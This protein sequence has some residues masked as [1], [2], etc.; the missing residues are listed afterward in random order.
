MGLPA[1]LCGQADVAAP[2]R[3]R[4]QRASARRM[5]DSVFGPAD[6]DADPDAAPAPAAEPRPPPVTDAERQARLDL[7]YRAFGLRLAKGSRPA[8]AGRSPT[9]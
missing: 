3:K 1:P 5:L 4:K 6:P 7:T 2:N 9:D 8:A